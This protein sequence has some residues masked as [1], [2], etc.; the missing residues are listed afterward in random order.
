MRLCIAF[1]VA[2]V[3][4]IV[5]TFGL[6]QIEM[7]ATGFSLPQAMTAVGQQVRIVE[8]ASPF[9]ARFE[10]AVT[11]G[12]PALFLP[13]DATAAA[14]ELGHAQWF[15]EGKAEVDFLKGVGKVWMA[16]FVALLATSFG[17]TPF[18]AKGRDWM[19]GWPGAAAR[20]RHLAW[21]ALI[22]PAMALQSAW[23]EADAHIRGAEILAAQ[24][25]APNATMA[26]MAWGTYGLM[27]IKATVGYLGI[28][29]WA[30][31]P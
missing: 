12:E 14:H 26:L 15:A 7:E 4:E 23:M 28:R 9:E 17:P 8:V 29:R 30:N 27:V 3:L 10:F 6:A 21:A 11:D 31:R 2:F 5:L 16:L 19:I 22:L 13:P 20:R 18:R 24:G 1:F 25:L